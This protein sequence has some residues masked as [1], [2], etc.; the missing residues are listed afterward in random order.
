MMHPR[1][2]REQSSGGTRVDDKPNGSVSTSAGGGV[3]SLQSLAGRFLA[4]GLVALAAVALQ[5]FDA[6]YSTRGGYSPGPREIVGSEP[7]MLLSASLAA[8]FLIG[9]IGRYAKRPFGIWAARLVCAL[10]GVGIAGLV[11]ASL[12]ILALTGVTYVG[13]AIGVGFTITFAIVC[14]AIGLAARGWARSILRTLDREAPV[15]SA[16]SVVDL[17]AA[18][19][20]VIV[21]LLVSFT[22]ITVMPA[23]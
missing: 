8:F 14:G 19:L 11:I 6:A 22:R 7:G 20:F 18:V 13:A 15:I 23:V 17:A 10:L 3:V 1:D 2:V 5:T 12:A 16:R 21:V 4:I 9:A